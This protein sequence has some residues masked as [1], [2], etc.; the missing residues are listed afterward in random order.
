MFQKISF[1]VLLV[2]GFSITAFS[3]DSLRAFYEQQK[4]EFIP[5][6][7]APE[8]GSQITLKISS[9]QQRTGILMK[10]S[11]DSL[12]IM[13]DTGATMN[14]ARGNLHETTRARFFAEDYAHI[15]ALEKTKLYKEE[16]YK[17]QVAENAAGIH[18]GRISVTAKSEKSSDKEVEE[19]ESE[20]KQ[21]GEKRITTTTTRT[22]TETQK[23]RV[24][25]SNLATH[26]DSF[27]VK[28]VFYSEGISKRGDNPEAV[29]PIKA[30]SDGQKKVT[31]DPRGRSE[32][33][34]TS[35]PIILTKI[36]M[37]SSHGYSSRENVSG[38]EAAGW[39]VQLLY[40]DEIL[41]QKASSNNLL[42]EK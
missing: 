41:D 32:I 7:I 8:M 42:P 24:N 27:T 9:G 16:L 13:S 39:L 14:Y 40:G 20:N 36:E 21:T 17:E 19:E 37:T 18:E 30:H 28:W 25:I 1:S 3:A 33:E 5:T 4:Q 35:E 34:I 11:A 26:P 2:L 12:T 31:L 29:T 23:L 10:L 15:K 38:D 22:Y 6:F